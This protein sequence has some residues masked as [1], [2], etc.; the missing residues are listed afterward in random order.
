MK[1]VK[2]SLTFKTQKMKAAFLGK[3]DTVPSLVGDLIIQ[4]EL[5]FQVGEEDELYGGY[6]RVMNS[7]PY[8]KFSCYDRELKDVDVN[9]AVLENDHLKAVF[10]P[11]RGGRLWSLWDKERDRELLFTNPVLRYGNLAVRNAWFSGGVEW[12]IGVIGHTPLTTSTLFTATLE[13][14]DGTPVLRMYEYERIRQVTYQMDFWLGEE[15]RFLNARMRIVNFGNDVV[16]MYWWSNIA[17]PASK[18]GRIITPARKA[19]TSAKGLVYKTDIP[20]VNGVDVTRYDNIPESVDYFFELE[21]CDP[22]YIAHVDG[23]G[24]GLLQMS[25]DR[26]RARKLFAWGKKTASDHWQEF[27]STEHE[28]KYVEIQAGLAKT[29]Y[30]CLPMSPHTAWEW[31][32]R[33]GAVFLSEEERGQGF[34]S[35]RDAV[36]KRIGEDPA[37]QEMGCVLESTKEM[38]RQCAEVKIKGSG[39]GAMKNR[40][41]A[42]EGRPPISEHLDFGTP[43]EKQE[44]WLRFLEDG[45]LTCPDPKDTPGLYPNDESIYVK[46]KETIKSKNKDNWYAHY[47]LGLYYFLKGRYKKAYRAFQTSADMRKNAWAYHGMASAAVMR[48]RNKKARKAMRKGI[49]MRERDLSYLK[50]GF[51]ILQMSG[52]Y[53]EICRLYSGLKRRFQKDGRLRLFYIKA[54]HETGRSREARELLNAD[55]GLV[56]NDIREGE[57]SLGELWLALERTVGEEPDQ[58]P[59]RFDFHSALVSTDTGKGRR[60]VDGVF[61]SKVEKL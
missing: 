50:E 6:G 14:E 27:L 28:G 46:L 24:Y 42:L 5:D 4:N 17:V 51:R 10:L 34:A 9:T 36:T 53:E 57:L 30:G 45:A 2:P 39:Y 19:F 8:S 59:Y 40:E 11:E 37:F 18:E 35:L 61:V 26:L 16:P 23:T 12:N 13:R 48:G 55:G 22:K 25:T 21:S 32:E 1:K 60:T 38:A 56:V 29:Q 44:V 43:E 41:R 47:N 3:E 49:A 58:V 54:L 52:G 31:L 7:Y 20:F 33:Y 15:D